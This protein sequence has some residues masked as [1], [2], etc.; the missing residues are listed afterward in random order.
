M[1]RASLLTNE[2]FVCLIKYRVFG[3]D[4]DDLDPS[5]VGEEDRDH[6]LFFR[7]ILEE[8]EVYGKDAVCKAHPG[9]PRRKWHHIQRRVGTDNLTY[10]N[11]TDARSAFW[12]SFE[13][14][15]VEKPIE[16]W[17]D[18]EISQNE[19]NESEEE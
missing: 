10:E 19:D 5:D 6:A 7:Y 15:H 13:D 1:L 8:F 3:I 17:Q 16:T 4:A 9:F 14:Y 11:V 12:E 2:E 18:I